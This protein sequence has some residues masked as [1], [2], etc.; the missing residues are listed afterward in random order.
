MSVTVL[1]VDDHPIVRQGLRNLLD[2]M[3]D[4]KVVGEAGDGLQALEMIEK[5]QPQVLVID[6]V[7]PG[8][9]GLEVT[10]RVKRQWPAVKVIILSMQNNEAY[11]VSALKSG[12]SGYILKDTGPEE[13]VDAI[14]TVVKGERYLSKQLSERI[15]NAYVS[16]MD[17][18][19]VDPYDTLTNRE[20][21]ILHLVAEGF[22]N[23]EIAERLFISP[24]TAELHR[25]NVLNKL[26][27][28][29]QV[30]LV[31]FAIK[32]GILPLDQ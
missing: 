10:Q 7:M 9:T 23:Q 31:R 1:L 4:F 3:P 28:K 26:S 2:S 21:E 22:T 29:N 27:L 19:E 8:L 11:V 5:V 18:A 6:V 32:R 24:R 13:L 25:S 16:K 15:I 12:A 30:D 17:E 14:R 20:K